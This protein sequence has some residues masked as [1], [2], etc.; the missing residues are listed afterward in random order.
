MFQANGRFPGTSL[1]RYSGLCQRNLISQIEPGD[2]VGYPRRCGRGPAEFQ[3]RAYAMAR[4]VDNF[5]QVSLLLEFGWIWFRWGRHFPIRLMAHLFLLDRL[6]YRH[7]DQPTDRLSQRNLQRSEC[8][9]KWDYDQA[10]MWVDQLLSN[11][12]L[13][14]ESYGC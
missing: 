13:L 9:P 1:Y 10:S 6:Q 7:L 12:V 4:K 11:G 5:R 2:R 14:E 8:S 3:R